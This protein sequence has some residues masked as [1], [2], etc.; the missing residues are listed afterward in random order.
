MESVTLAGATVMPPVPPSTTGRASIDDLLEH[1][2]GRIL[3]QFGIEHALG[4]RWRRT[5]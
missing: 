4:R 5:S 2:A 1:L 3:D